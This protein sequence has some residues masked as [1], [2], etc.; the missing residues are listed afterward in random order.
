MARAS[1]DLTPFGVPYVLRPGFDFKSIKQTDLK[2]G[3]RLKGPRGNTISFVLGESEDKYTVTD[4]IGEGTYGVVYEVESSDKKRYAIKCIKEKLTDFAEFIAFIKET[5]IQLLVVEVSKDSPNGPYAPQIYDICYDADTGEG[6]VLS[7]LMYNTFENLVSIN[8]LGANDSIVPDCLLQISTIIKELQASLLFNHRDMKGDN[9]MYIKEDGLHLYCLIDFGM[10]CI[11]WHGMKISGSSWFDEKHSCF[12]KDRDLSQFI[13][14]IQRY[15]DSHLSNELVYRL[16]QTIIA[17]IGRRHTC[18]MHKLC[19]EYGLRK[20]K[21]IYNFVDR[22]NVNIPG[23]TPIFVKSN[24]TRFITGKK[25][26]P[27]RKTLRRVRIR[28]NRVST[29]TYVDSDMESAI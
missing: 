14:Y 13:F 15:L 4:K 19:P 11:T 21:N 29:V 6:Y 1:F 23:G 20:W 10:S 24:M 18:K 2:Y 9:V 12:K 22:R 26:K 27:P 25:F 5:I 17:N 3:K 16:R 28:P 7:E 8:T